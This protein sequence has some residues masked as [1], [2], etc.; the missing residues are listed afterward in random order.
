LIRQAKKQGD[1]DEILILLD[2]QAMDKEPVG[3]KF[4][5]RL[6]MVNKVFGRDPKISIGLSNRGLF[7]Q[8][9]KP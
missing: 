5:D 4:E 7:L 1:L 9:L 6:T 8:K 2:I 3:A